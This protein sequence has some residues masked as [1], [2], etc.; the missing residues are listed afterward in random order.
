MKSFSVVESGIGIVCFVGE[1][2]LVMRLPGREKR[3]MLLVVA[4]KGASWS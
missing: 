3:I 1:N 2:E 4:K